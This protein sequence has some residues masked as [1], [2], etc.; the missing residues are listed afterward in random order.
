MD[1]A[2]DSASYSAASPPPLTTS[3]PS[4]QST[5]ASS[6][7]LPTTNASTRSPNSSRFSLLT[8]TSSRSTISTSLKPTSSLFPTRI[9][10]SLSP[11][12]KDLMRKMLSRDVSK[13]F[14]AEQVLTEER[15]ISCIIRGMYGSVWL[16]FGNEIPHRFYSQE[17]QDSALPVTLPGPAL[18]PPFHSFSMHMPRRS[19]A[20]GVEDEDKGNSSLINSVKPTMIQ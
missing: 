6:S 4:N 19:R 1:A 10:R 18:V 7:T 3:S 11:A 13:R 14:S 16:P 2:D 9:F 5:N 17:R 20:G 8:L 12:A 15:D